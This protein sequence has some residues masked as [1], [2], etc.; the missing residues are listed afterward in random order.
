MSDLLAFRNALGRVPSGYGE[1]HVRTVGF[2]TGE[3]RLRSL[4]SKDRSYKPVVKSSGAQRESDG[5]VVP[6]IAGRNP[7][8]GKDP[9]FGHAGDG[10]TRE[11][12]TGTAPSNYPDGRHLPPVKVRQLQNRLWAAAKQS[13]GRRFHALYDRIYRSDVLWEAWQRVRANRG[14]AGVDQVTL[15]VVEA[16]GVERMLAE[17]QERLRAGE[18][19]PAPVRRVEIPKP[20]GSKR[21]LGIPTVTD[22]VCQQAA[23][24]VL[25]PVF[26]A[27]F[28]PCSFGFRPKRSATDA[29]EKIRVAFPRGQ[30]FV[31]E[32]DIK[33]FFGSLDQDKLLSLVEERVSDRRVL[34]L[35]RQWLR[36][37]VLVDGVFSETVTG[38]PQGGVISPLL[39]NIYLHAFDRAW[40]VRGIGE[41]VRYADDF[42]VLCETREQAERAQEAATAILGELGLRLHP[43]KTRV[44]DLGEGRE[45]FDFLGC[46]LHARMSGK[47]WEQRRVVRY[48]LHRWPSQRSMKRARARIKA[49][50]GRSQVGMELKAVIGRL[51][52][53][54]RGWGNYFRTG[55]AATKFVT[56]DR[57][58]AWR[59]RRLLIKKRG[60]NLRAGQADHWTRTWFH[61]QGLY[62][63]MGT[64][65]YPKA[66]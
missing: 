24:I 56:M 12:M 5:V 45:G 42:V 13:E 59:L 10:G 38:T 60:R 39:A 25:E 64:I 47:Q 16:Y 51:N 18:Y 23:K 1:R 44:V 61:D 9:D 48:Y 29:L 57:Y 53:F 40:A 52:L 2:G 26:E 6:P 27:D 36:A 41:L 37:G 66:A 17:L 3:A 19:R 33:D 35:V 65:R 21:P 54:L 20:D 62:K 4:V 31:F 14:A 43:D 7:A 30:Q 22:R 11:G 63:L 15:G 8:G 55:N 46:H 34:K 28:L 50:T 32:A 49:L 58:V